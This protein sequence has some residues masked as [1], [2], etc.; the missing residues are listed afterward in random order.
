M[1]SNGRAR[2]R[3]PIFV[4]GNRRSMLEKATGFATDA[5][6]AD[7]EDSVPMAEKPAARDLVADMIPAL[8]KS[9]QRVIVRVNSLDTGLAVD[10]ITAVVQPDV[11][12]I[13]VGKITSPGDIA[14]YSGLLDAAEAKAGLPA[15]QTLLIPWIETAAAVLHAYD[16]ARASKRVV[17]ITFG[18]ED[19]TRDVGIR[20]TASG[21]EVLFPRS[22]VALAAHAAGVTPLDTPYV[23][24]RDSTGLE[25]DIAEA[26]RLGYKGKFAIHPA[27]LEPIRRLFGP[28][29]DEIEYAQRVLAAWDAAS[30]DGRGSL[31]LDGAMVDV[32]VVERARNTLAEAAELGLA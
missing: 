10:D 19:Y 22:L 13:S 31:D 3:N 29:P 23:N 18:A 27:Q 5:V 9:G 25:S 17:A 6:V 2:V 1:S 24:F 4:P 26:V 16:I 21:E 30:A 20:R 7:L 32:P 15:G 12:A 14:E 11:F 28:Q 8:A